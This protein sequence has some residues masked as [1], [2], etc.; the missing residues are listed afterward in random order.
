MNEPFFI[1]EDKMKKLFFILFML[2]SAYAYALDISNFKD[3]KCEKQNMGES[4]S[5][6]ISNIYLCTYKNNIT[7]QDAY[8][9]VIDA[10]EKEVISKNNFKSSK[11][12][13][14]FAS[15]I[16]DLKT[17][18]YDEYTIKEESKDGV[19][20]LISRTVEQTAA[21]IS[22][23]MGIKD[24]YYSFIITKEGSSLQLM[25]SSFKGDEYIEAN[26]SFIE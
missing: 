20:Y 6:I 15:K 16:N 25:F 12:K 2:F 5:N 8:Y 9:D 3:A 14:S 18:K 22:T 23:N 21:E 7:F 26:K 13:E 4:G 10:V 24:E 1:M 19:L 11:E 17:K